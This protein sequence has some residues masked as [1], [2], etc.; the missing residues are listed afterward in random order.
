M[1]AVEIADAVAELA[2]APFDPA[3]FPFAFLAAFGNKETTLKRLRAG[4][5][6]KSDLGGVLQRGNIHIKVCPADQ[7]TA[8]LAA[9]R[10]SPA[11]AAQK[12]KFILATDGAHLEAENLGDGETIACAFSELGADEYL[13]GTGVCLIEW[14]DRVESMLPAEHLRIDIRIVGESRREFTLE[15]KGASYK[16]LLGEIIRDV[17]FRVP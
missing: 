16:R 9:L 15:A 1:N 6:N 5:T 17:P 14:A 7:V 4:S 11:T 8:T 12:A 2:D 10:E 3:E 13:G